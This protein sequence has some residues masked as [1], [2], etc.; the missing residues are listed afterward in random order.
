MV[1]IAKECKADA[2]KFQ[3]Y[4][5]DEFISNKNKKY[6]YKIKNKVKSE[7][8]YSI[9]KRCELSINDWKKIKNKC[10]KE[11]IIFLSTPSSYDDLRLLRKLKVPAIK[12]GSDDF[13]NIPLIQSVV[14]SKLL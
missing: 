3:T 9:F 6:K 12:I 2:I 11:K 8:M 14:K 7:S 1:E 5:T 4:S 13:N 10:D